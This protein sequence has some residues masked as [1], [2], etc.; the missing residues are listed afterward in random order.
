MIEKL[1]EYEQYHLLMELEIP[2]AI[3]LAEMEW[4]GVKVDVERLKLMG[5]EIFTRLQSI[6][7][8]IFDLAGEA[9]NIN[10]PKQLGTILFE[11]L[12]LPALKKT[13]TGYSTSADVLEKLEDQA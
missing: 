11:K 8:K 1:E 9:F 3:I 5:Q 4:Q 6:E 2:L 12:E 10:S 13:K 7:T